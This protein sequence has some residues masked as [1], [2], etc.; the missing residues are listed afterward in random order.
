MNAINEN[1]AYLLGLLYGKGSIF[2]IDN[3]IILKFRVKFRRPTDMSVRADNI[4]TNNTD[5]EY[6]ES[7]K[8]KL[9][10]DFSTI[11]R[12]LFHAWKITSTIDLPNSY[13]ASDWNMK[14]IVITSEVIPNDFNR[15]KELLNADILDNECLKRFPFHLEMEKRRPI[16]LS[17]IQGICDSC[18]LVPNEA[19]NGYGGDGI[20]R[21]QLEPSQER[22]E[23]PIGICRLFQ[24]GLGI[25][26][27]NINWGHPQIRHSWKHQ[28]HQFRVS[29]KNIPKEIELYRL[30]YKKEEYDNLYERSEVEY[31]PGEKCPYSK[32]VKEKEIIKLNKNNS[33]DLNNDLLDSRLKGIDVN[34]SGK[35]SL[36]ICKLLGCEQ[37]KDYFDIQII[38]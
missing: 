30:T 28:N 6:V 35:K 26:V 4:H 3:G 5:R 34:V 33:E 2:P 11:I 24:I 36:C 14:E 25:Q 10:N 7:L 16:A 23:L 22:W 29:M 18:S 27:N 20:C 1:E 21:I 37:C 13:S 12:I 32:R 8:S 9:T 19:A 17:F 38:D 31:E 15:L